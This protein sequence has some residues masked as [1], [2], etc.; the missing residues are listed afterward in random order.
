MSLKTG[1]AMGFET[2]SIASLY[3]SI[4]ISAFPLSPFSFPML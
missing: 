1:T 4:A 3:F 2:Y